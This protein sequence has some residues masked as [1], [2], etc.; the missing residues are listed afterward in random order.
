MVLGFLFLF[1][2]FINGNPDIVGID[3]GSVPIIYINIEKS[4]AVD[5]TQCVRIYSFDECGVKKVL[6]LVL[7]PVALQSPTNDIHL[8]SDIISIIIYNMIDV[9]KM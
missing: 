7:F 3:D 4:V 5:I 2:F 8:H 1:Y 6:G 9:Q